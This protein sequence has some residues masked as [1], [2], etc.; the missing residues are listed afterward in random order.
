M[1][2]I[3]L[4]K[5]WQHFWLIIPLMF[6]FPLTASAQNRVLQLDGHGDYVQLPSDIFNDLD[7]ATVEG[8]RYPNH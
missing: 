1:R 5:D 7:N 6:I 4:C 3:L 2:D 8:W